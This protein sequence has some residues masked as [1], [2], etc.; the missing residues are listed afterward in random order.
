MHLNGRFR[1]VRMMLRSGD[2]A[3]KDEGRMTLAAASAHRGNGRIT[4]WPAC[5]LL[6]FREPRTIR[7]PG[8]SAVQGHT[9][10]ARSVLEK[11]NSK[12]PVVPGQE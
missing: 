8:I 11:K 1:S 9:E 2:F 12:R 3:S 5:E 4:V 10:K 6:F 7:P